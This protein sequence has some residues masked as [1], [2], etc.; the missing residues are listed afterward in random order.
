[1]QY[2][3]FQNSETDKQ[4]QYHYHKLYLSC[5][6]GNKHFLPTGGEGKYAQGVLAIKIL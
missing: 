6:Q 1:M 4:P 2:S 3:S 5:P